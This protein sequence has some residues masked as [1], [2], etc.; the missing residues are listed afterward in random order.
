[1]PA[2]EIIQKLL[3]AGNNNKEVCCSA[4]ID[5]EFG[6]A[7]DME[8]SCSAYH[9]LP[10]EGGYLDQPT[11]M[12]EMFEVIRSEKQRFENVQADKLLS[13]S[14]KKGKKR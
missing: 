5:L 3:K 4:F 14:K 8:S 13:D 10:Y 9:V 2:F 11:R 1:M 7:I 12:M 6:T